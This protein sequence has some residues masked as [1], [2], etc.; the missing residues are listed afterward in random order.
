M[1]IIAIAWMYVAVLMAA[2]EATNANGSILGAIITFF[3]YGL[4]PMALVMYLLGAPARRKAR[5]KKEHD[6]WLAQQ[7]AQDANASVA[8]PDCSAH[9]AGDAP[10]AAERKEP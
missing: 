10:V 8:D 7:Q 6:E 9:A 2:A 4:A 3:L 5:K 1:W